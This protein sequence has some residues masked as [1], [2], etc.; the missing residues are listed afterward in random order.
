M[1]IL[2]AI[3]QSGSNQNIVEYLRGY[4][5]SEGDELK[6]LHVVE[7]LTVGSYM[8]ILPGPILDEIKQKAFADGEKVVHDTAEM[9]RSI[10]PQSVVTAEV[11]NGFVVDTIVE[12]AKS[13]SADFIAVAAH[14]RRGANKFTLGSI[15]RAIVNEGPCS[16]ILVSLK[17]A[18]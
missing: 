14:G 2:V 15:A 18:A 8:S 17:P 9:L 5:L 7:P 12:K 4:K 11:Q 1:K 3:D 10:F 13:W 6:V 16:V